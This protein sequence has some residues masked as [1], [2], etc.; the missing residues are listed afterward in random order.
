MDPSG[1]V[2]L[3]VVD[4]EISEWERPSNKQRCIGKGS[5]LVS[6]LFVSTNLVSMKQ[7]VKPESIRVITGTGAELHRKCPY[8]EIEREEGSDKVARVG[9]RSTN[10]KEDKEEERETG[11]TAGD[12]SKGEEWGT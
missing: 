9:E 8:R 6:S 10:N 4:L 11:S 1:K 2:Q 12:G 5:N 3:K 7:W